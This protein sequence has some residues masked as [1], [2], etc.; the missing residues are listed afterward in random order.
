MTTGTTAQS[1][2]LLVLAGF[3]IAVLGLNGYLLGVF[4]REITPRGGGGIEIPG[5]N[6]TVA[7]QDI[8]SAMSGRVSSI[9][10]TYGPKVTSFISWRTVI[11]RTATATVDGITQ[12]STIAVTSIVYTVVNTVYNKRSNGDEAPTPA[13]KYRGDKASQITPAPTGSASTGSGSAARQLHKR[14]KGGGGDGSGSGNGGSDGGSGGSGGGPNFHIPDGSGGGSSSGGDSSGS[15][16]F[17]YPNQF[18][19][20]Y[21]YE[22]N[23][24]GYV[25]L[26]V[27]A[28]LV[29]AYA[30]AHLVMSRIRPNSRLISVLADHIAHAVLLA[31]G[32]AG[33]AAVSAASAWKYWG[34][35]RGAVY[36]NVALAWV[37][38]AILLG[39]AIFELLYIRRFFPGAANRRRSVRGLD[40]TP[41]PST[42]GYRSTLVLYGYRRVSSTGMTWVPMET[43]VVTSEG[44]STRTPV[45]MSRRSEPSAKPYDQVGTTTPPTPTTDAVAR[46]TSP[47]RARHV[48][49]STHETPALQKRKKGGGGGGGSSH[50]GDIFGNLTG[51]LRKTFAAYIVVEVW[52]GLVVA[53]VVLQKINAML[54]LAW[55]LWVAVSPSC[56]ALAHL[57]LLGLVAAEAYYVRTYFPG[58]ENQRSSL[59]NLIEGAG[60][61]AGRPRHFA[62]GAPISAKDLAGQH[63]THPVIKASEKTSVQNLQRKFAVPTPQRPPMTAS[64]LQKVHVTDLSSQHSERNSVQNLQRKFSVPTPQRPPMTASDLGKVHITK[65]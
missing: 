31:L 6:G 34:Q 44:F 48:A 37:M 28:A 56:A 22:T 47:P 35:Y 1:S 39:L 65:S 12:Y 27:W 62:P 53:Y 13:A 16:S 55:I 50:S 64:D 7:P 51:E 30:I 46:P 15:G 32:L 57:K 33:C 61:G 59:L 58:D 23:M 14:K 19:L 25:V 3:G 54:A 20:P 9:F 18:F 10:D 43:T 26:E 49:K 21:S 29:A 2:L 41:T 52:A 63:P 36:A 60:G 4:Y 5:Y 38:W 42:S 8:S 11:D 17:G 40:N 45:P 24:P